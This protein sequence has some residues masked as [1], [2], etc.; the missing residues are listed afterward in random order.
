[1]N[2][3]AQEIQVHFDP[4]HTV[5]SDVA[6]RN[7]VTVT[8]QGAIADKLG[9]TSGFLDLDFNQKNGNIGLAYLELK[10][11]FRF[12]RFPLLLHLEFNGGV[13]KD[14]NGSGF[15]LPNAYLAGTGYARAL[16]KLNLS[17]YLVYK[18]N[19]FEKSSHD[20][21]WSLLW[22]VKLW[23]SRITLSGFLDVWTENKDRMSGRG[24]KK[25][26]LL[27]EPQFWYNFNRHFALGTEIEISNN[28]Y[29]K[30]KSRVYVF[31]TLAAKWTF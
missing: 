19:S 20:V 5:H 30:Y 2:A 17:T 21:Q 9:S 10:R 26:I 31:P 13:S 3:A 6:P 29:A 24:G 18:Y 16:G 11:D 25:M 8:F 22:S 7:Y 12:N 14:R 15:S 23:D 28:F 1:M 4:R 27:T